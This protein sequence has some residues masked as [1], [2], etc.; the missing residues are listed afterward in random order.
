M[1]K[2]VDIDG[3]GH[4]DYSEFI[5]AAADR[6]KLLS[7]KNLEGAFNMFDKDGSG[8]IT[9]DEIKH[10]LGPMHKGN[11]DVWVKVIA[12]VDIDGNGE[13]DLLEFKNM[14]LRLF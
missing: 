7:K 1:M 3:S 12:E 11:T 9:I 10:V 5:S 8:S 2:E 4:I 6:K 14:M 13:I